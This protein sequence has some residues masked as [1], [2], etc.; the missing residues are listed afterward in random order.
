MEENEVTFFY[1]IWLQQ[2]IA[3]YQQHRKATEK[4]TSHGNQVTYYWI[5]TVTL[6]NSRR[7]FKTS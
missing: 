1:C 2:N 4:Y 7:K 3:R 6:K 5:M